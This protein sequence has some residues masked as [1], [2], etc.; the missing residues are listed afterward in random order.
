MKRSRALTLLSMGA[1]VL[2]LTACG[3]NSELLPAKV[4]AS[5]EECVAEGARDKTQCETAM[6]AAEDAYEE[7]YPKFESKGQCE[8][9]AGEGSCEKDRPSSRDSQWRPS[10]VGFLIGAAIG[11]RVQPQPVLPST[12]SASGYS[13]A[14]GIAIARSGTTAG[15]PASAAGRASSAQVTKVATAARGGFGHS[16]AAHVSTGGMRSGG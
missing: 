3:N 16:A 10:M 13:T 8:E 5:V 9:V 1:S 6:M 7:A 12:S 11:S 2:A 4:Y 14:A 15:V